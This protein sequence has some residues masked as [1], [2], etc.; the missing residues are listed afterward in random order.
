[1]ANLKALFY[2]VYSY[3]IFIY[4]GRKGQ[5][6]FFPRTWP[7]IDNALFPRPFCSSVSL[8]YWPP[9]L[10]P[11]YPILGKHLS[12]ISSNLVLVIYISGLVQTTKYGFHSP[13]GIGCPK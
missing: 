1:M 9:S 2:V 10:Y 6:R 8:L 3:M 12:I 5:S 13:V 7:L 11:Q 4:F